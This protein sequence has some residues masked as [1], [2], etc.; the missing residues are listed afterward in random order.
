MVAIIKGYRIDF[1][2]EP[3]QRVRPH[4][5]QYSVEQSQ[6][7]VEEIKELLGKGAII[8]AHNPRGGFYSNLFFVPK[9]DG[10]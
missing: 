4:T 9:K 1:L 5:P 6:L 3:H 7:I 8:E 10:G 2:S